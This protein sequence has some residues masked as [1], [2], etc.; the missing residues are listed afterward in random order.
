MNNRVAIR[1]LFLLWLAASVQSLCV[2]D[3]GAP[4]PT[5]ARDFTDDYFGTKVSDPYRWMEDSKSAEFKSWIKAQASYAG[6]NLG[7][8]RTR[9]KLLKRLEE[10]SNANADVS[11]VSYVAGR[12]FYYKVA[13]G[14]NDR[15]L[16]VRDGK[17]APER[18][19]I[20]V[21]RL[22]ESGKRYSI[23]A[24]SVSQDARYVSYFVIARR[25]GVRRAARNGRP[26]RTRSRRTHRSHAMVCRQLAARWPFLYLFAVAQDRC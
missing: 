15:A 21:A 2:A 10:L 17:N 1:G 26:Q 18:V 3:S 13:P 22:S 11:S 20:D 6:A 5:E 24:Y 8:L 7:R 12:Y 19:L 14:E 16:Y 4:P 25:L 9:A 23:T